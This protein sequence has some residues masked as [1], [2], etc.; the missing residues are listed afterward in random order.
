MKGIKLSTFA[1]RCV[2][3]T[4]F[5][6]LLT[7][8][9]QTD[10]TEVLSV[11]IGFVPT[12]EAQARGIDFT[13]DNLTSLGVLA[14]LTQGSS[15]NALS[16]TP[17]F[18]YNQEVTKAT[19]A[20]TWEYTPTKFWPTNSNDKITFFAY[21]P[22]NAKGLTLPAATD[23]GYPSFTYQVQAAEAAQIDLLVCTPLMNQTYA[24][25]SGKVKFVMNHALTKIAIYVKNN[26]N[27]S[28]KTITAFS[29][30][31]VKSG[32]LTF[33]SLDTDS[34]D[35][36]GIILRPSQWK[37]LPLLSLISLYPSIVLQ[38]R[39]CFLLSSYYLTDREIHSASLINIQGRM[40]LRP[41]F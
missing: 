18:M 1:A 39:S 4:T 14:Y 19:G 7:A 24:T 15:F 30:R 17:N 41:L 33:Q 22:H 9:S 32:T 40:E 38:K 16:S 27:V 29:I 12:V 26:D 21:A 36:S 25:N 11:S 37:H 23:R 5:C 31:G 8:C 20:S 3:L 34:K 13:K 10:E 6:V 28:E 2:L 35:S